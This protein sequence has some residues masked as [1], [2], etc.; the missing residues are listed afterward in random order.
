MARALRA[1]PKRQN[2]AGI[3]RYSLAASPAI[4]F[5][6]IPKTTSVARSV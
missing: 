1:R 4:E 3:D 6:E 5:V 2:Q